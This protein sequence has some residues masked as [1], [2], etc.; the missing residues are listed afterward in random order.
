MF[1]LPI[2]TTS[3]SVTSFWLQVKGKRVI[4]E[5]EPPT[6]LMRTIYDNLGRCKIK[7]LDAFRDCC[8]TSIFASMEPK[9][10][11]KC[12]WH[13][14]VQGLVKGKLLELVKLLQCRV[15]SLRYPHPHRCRL[16][17]TPCLFS[18]VYSAKV[19]ITFAASPH[20]AFA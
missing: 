8:E 3:K 11:R 20:S 18:S 2:R 5:N 12:T 6:G 14:C 19:I 4:P 1:S 13:M 16:P 10:R 9:F 15:L 7:Q 17:S